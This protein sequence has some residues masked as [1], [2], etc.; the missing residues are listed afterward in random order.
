MNSAEHAAVGAVASALAVVA[1]AARR[2][3]SRARAVALWAYGVA[4]SVG[5]DFD[6]FPLARAEA[7]DWAALR[8]ALRRPTAALTDPDYVFPDPTLGLAPLRLRSHLAIGTALTAAIALLA[9]PIAAFT[10]VVLAVH[11][12]C[13][14]LR[15][16][17]V[18]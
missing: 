5:I 2:P 6:H 1:L 14:L 15:D 10:A 8:R 17:G 9:P 11:V 7:G 4:L 3:L 13:D 12:A 18:A 16:S